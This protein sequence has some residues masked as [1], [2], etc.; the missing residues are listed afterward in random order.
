MR[1]R[2]SR[3]AVSPPHLEPLWQRY[4]RVRAASERLCQPLEAEDYVVQS[5]QDVSPPKWHLAHVTWF[6][7]AFVLQ[8]FLPGYRPLDE[9]YDH[10]FNSYYKTHGTPFERA[11]RGLL[12]RPTVREVYAYRRH[13]DLAMAQLLDQRDV[14]L[15]DE[16][17]QRI[18]L[19][20]EHEQQHQELLL[21]DIKHILAQNPLRPVYRHDLKPGGAAASELRWIEFPAGLRQVGHAGEDF[22]F[23]CERPRHRVFVE[24]FQLASRPV[25]N[26]EYL[27]FI[28]DGGYRSTALWLADG[29]DH[30]QRA[31][32][33]APLYWLREG[34]D[35]L[36]LT[37]GG[38]R[39]LDLDAPVCHLSY[40]EAEAFATWAQAR[41]PREEE[42]E[43]AAQDEPLRGNFV[44]NDHLQPVAAGAGDG[45][46][47]LYGDVWEWTASAY[48]PY[49]GFRPLGGSL[50]EY[51][52]KFMS[53]QMVLR[54]GCCATPE[55]HVRPTY[56]NFFYPTM[57]WQ[58]SGL[59]L[60]KEL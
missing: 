45:L 37:L 56:R 54:G 7:E 41:L 50:G 1:D 43:V 60:A 11:R 31:G 6:F 57:R 49:P 13:V 35:W 16:V 9:R 21:M 10:L 34:D 24:A 32:W 15:A 29:W 42:W 38:P 30:I 19:G 20:L 40:F 17:L 18:A 28:R 5:M 27:E 44:E 33:Q 52:G 39:E 48:R 3:I 23:D 8:P 36:E 55:D 26:G 14:E 46:Q 59:R 4:Q 25:S 2:T 53:G 51:N 47:Q 58:F 12:S 22:A